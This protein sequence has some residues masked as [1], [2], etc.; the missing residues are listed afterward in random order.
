M[1]D[2]AQAETP[3]PQ[4]S[5]S[6]AKSLDTPAQAE[7]RKIARAEIQAITKPTPRFSTKENT[8]LELDEI[9]VYGQR[10]PEDISPK[11]K[12]PLQQFRERLNNDRPLTPAEKA[13][14]VLCAIGMCNRYNADGAPPEPSV[15][16]RN[17]ARLYQHFTP[18]FG[19]GTLQ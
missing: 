1:A 5:I 13:S 11:R 10:E 7:V 3:A 19:R 18:G 16:D 8:V 4:T 14:I 12:P 15:T 6:P 17:E 2:G 9:R